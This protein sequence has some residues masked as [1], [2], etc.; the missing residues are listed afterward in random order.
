MIGIFCLIGGL[1]LLWYTA[2][3]PMVAVR[4]LQQLE[5]SARQIQM[6]KC[7]AIQS[8]YPGLEHLSPRE[9]SQLYD[10]DS[11]YDQIGSLRE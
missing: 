7:F 1:A 9:I 6:Y 2:L 11:V 10:I 3:A 4:R 8:Y 5:R